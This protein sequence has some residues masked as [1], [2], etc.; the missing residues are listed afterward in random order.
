M[1]MKR[2]TAAGLAVALDTVKDALRVSSDV[3]EDDDRLEQLI[4][5]ETARYEAFTGRVLLPT[6]Y[7]LSLSGWGFP[8]CLPV[9]PVR[10]VTGVT[11]LDAEHVEQTL[12]V[13]AW[14]ATE[15]APQWSVDLV[16]NA[17]LPVLS[18][19]PWPVRVAFEA[20]HD[21]PAASGGGDD[22]LL[23]P[24]P[25]DA[26]AI[27]HMVGVIFDQGFPLD[28]DSMRKMFGARRVI[29]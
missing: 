25:E 21:D 24:R 6:T 12:S 14:Y 9:M 23:A 19:R 28:F 11:Y 3:T 16:S 8:V 27:I 13:G 29:G 20:G 17:G 1:L 10:A 4:R 7:R 26:D 15:A 2:S 22:A 5:S 18:D